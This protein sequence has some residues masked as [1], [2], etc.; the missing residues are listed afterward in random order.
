MDLSLKLLPR[1]LKTKSQQDCDLLRPLSY[2]AAGV[3]LTCFFSIDSPDSLENYMKSGSCS[4][5]NSSEARASFVSGTKMTF[6]RTYA[7][8]EVTKTKRNP[9]PVPTGR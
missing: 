8:S 3:V 9:G 7:L 1:D 2:S 5:A 6:E 4:Y